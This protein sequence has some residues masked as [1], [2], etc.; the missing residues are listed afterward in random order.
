MVLYKIC[1]YYSVFGTKDVTDYYN[2]F[3]S[4]LIRSVNIRWHPFAFGSYFKH[5]F[6]DI[7]TISIFRTIGP[8][9]S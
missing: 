8:R 6:M 4:I 5:I 1:I 2:L 7:E 9:N 3:P